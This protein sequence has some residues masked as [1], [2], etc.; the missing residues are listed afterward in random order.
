MDLLFKLSNTGGLEPVVSYSNFKEH[1][2]AVNDNLA[3]KSLEPSIRRATTD[4]LIPHISNE[5]YTAIAEVYV[6]GGELSEEQ[7]EFLVACQDTVATYTMVLALPELNVTVGEMG[8]VDKGSTSAPTAPAPQ[9]R[10]KELKY[11]L[12]KK[13][14][15]MLDRCIALLEKYT[16]DGVEFFEGWK[17]TKA[18]KEVRTSF[19]HSAAE[20]DRYVRINSSRRLFSQIQ[21][22]IILVEEEIDK[23]ICEDQFNALVEAIKDG[24]ATDEENALIEQIRRY[25]ASK[26]MA[27]AAAGLFLTIDTTGLYLSSYTDGVDSHNH[28]SAVARGA[29]AVG[30]FIL[31]LQTDASYFQQVMMNFIHTHIDDYPDIEESDCYAR[32]LHSKVGPIDVGPGGIFI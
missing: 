1:Y 5:V 16:H 28:F 19:F 29:E 27:K 26:A 12:C 23:I 18:Y 31:K 14:D 2:S 32:Y 8:V 11:D 24:D 15:K 3:W 21:Q 7:M 30:N 10:Y 17:D 25:V 20:F 4:Y 6:A 22:D 9:W 13:A